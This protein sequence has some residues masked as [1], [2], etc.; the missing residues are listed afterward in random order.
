MRI[1]VNGIWC[2]TKLDWGFKNDRAFIVHIFNEKL[3]LEALTNDQAK[4]IERL[5][6]LLK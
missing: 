6:G 5:L 3:R 2:D 1:K 4:E